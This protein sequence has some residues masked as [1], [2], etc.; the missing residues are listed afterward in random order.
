[1]SLS[2]GPGRPG[3]RL[4]V[5]QLDPAALLAYRRSSRTTRR[6]AELEL[7]VGIPLRVD[8][9]CEF[10]HLCRAGA[11]QRVRVLPCTPARPVLTHG[12]P[13]SAT[14]QRACREPARLGFVTTEA[15]LEKHGRETQ[16]AC[17]LDV[18]ARL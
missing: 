16:A 7:A 11:V 15:S 4:R 3:R 10:E 18:A 1:M 13:P 6:H 14:G 9:L 17:R 8:F 12:V 2:H 5:S